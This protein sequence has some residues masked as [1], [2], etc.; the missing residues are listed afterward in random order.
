MYK[1]RFFELEELVNPEFFKVLTETEIWAL[2]DESALRMLDL[3]RLHFEKPVTVNNWHVGGKFKDRGLRMFDCKT[4]AKF[5]QHKFGRAFD[6]DV[7]GFTAEQIRNEILK[8]KDLFCGI[9]A[10]E[11]NVDWVHFDTR[12][13]DNRIMRI[14][15]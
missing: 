9:K 10:L 15:P 12:Q 6:L 14:M 2:L 11:I 1:C 7:K 3:I 5:S 13:V 8:N 4:G